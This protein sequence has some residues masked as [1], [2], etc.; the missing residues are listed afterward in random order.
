MKKHI[1]LTLW[2]LLLLFVSSN[3]QIKKLYLEAGVSANSYKGSLNEGFGNYTSSFNLGIRF[4]K[5]QRLNGS[6]NFL[7]GNIDGQT[8]VFAVKNSKGDFVYP[9]NYFKTSLV[10]FDYS[11]RF[12][13]ISKKKSLLYLG[14]GVGL[15]RFNVQDQ[16]GNNLANNATTRDKGEDYSNM[17]LSFP[18]FI[19]YNY[20]LSNDYRLGVQAQF[21]NPRTDYL[22][23]TSNW[24]PYV[25]SDN[26]LSFKFFLSVPIN[27]ASN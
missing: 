20:I 8:P 26:V 6:V 17:S 19:G 27:L 13:L 9:P 22:D 18:V 12:N 10:T 14:G 23:N 5:K 1:I 4:C 2:F 7:Y 25:T 21:L 3:A 15:L 24:S 11:L 16:D